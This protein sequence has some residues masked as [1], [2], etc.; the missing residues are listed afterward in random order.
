[1]TIT[2]KVENLQFSFSSARGFSLFLPHLSVQAG[3]RILLLGPS[4]SGKSTFLNLLS[5]VLRPHSGSV[6]IL[7]RDITQL[8]A[9]EMD[10]FRGDHI[11]IIFQTLNLIPW[12]SAAQN[13]ALGQVFSARRRNQLTQPLGSEIAA[14]LDQLGLPASQFAS[15]RAEQLSIGQQQRIGAGRALI[16]CPEIILAD[17]PTSALDNATTQGFMKVLTSSLN[18]SRQVLIMVSHDERLADHFSRVVHLDGLLRHG[19]N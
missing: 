2:L 14:L 3:E 12:L 6:S 19:D 8:K 13:I 10:R 18:P 17:E 11:G 4:G 16:G 7:G 15:A 1:M 5:G 9:S